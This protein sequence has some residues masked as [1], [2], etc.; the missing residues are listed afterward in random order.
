VTAAGGANQAAVSWQP[1]TAPAA[2]ITGYLVTAYSGTTPVNSV[3]TGGSATSATI[4]GLAGGTV[5]TFKVAAED[6][7]GFG[8][9]GTSGAV[10]PTGSATTYA[11]KV[12][13]DGPSAYWRLGE[14][15]GSLAADSSGNG[16]LLNYNPSNVTLGVAGGI[17]GD[18]DTAISANGCC[19]GAAQGTVPA[20]PQF[21]SARTVVAWVNLGTSA[22]NG[23]YIA[24]WGNGNTAQAFS[25]Y[26]AATQIAVTTSGNNLAFTPSQALDD[27]AWHEV[28]VTYNGSQVTAYVDGIEV[29]S[30]APFSQSLNTRGTGFYLVSYF[31]SAVF[32]GDLDDVAVFPKALTATQ[33]ATLHTTA[34]Y[35]PVHHPLRARAASRGRKRPVVR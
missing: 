34:G 5:Y 4:S 21:N 12:I 28:A 15:S 35:T 13:A 8:P 25:L 1:A 27:G 11:S 3:A 18:P 2:G 24:S 32:S 29:G 30:P 33:I 20:L 17:V 22:N 19:G 10:T 7:Y 26:A 9:A 16:G 31:N 6:A 23:G 14:P